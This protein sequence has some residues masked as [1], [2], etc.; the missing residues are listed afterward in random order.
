MDNSRRDELLEKIA[1][2]ETE[3]FLALPSAGGPSPAQQKPEIFKWT[4]KMTHAAHGEAFLESLLEDLQ[5]AKRQ[6]RNILQE[7]YE[8]AKNGDAHSDNPVADAIADVEAGFLAQAGEKYPEILKGGNAESFRYYLRQELEFLSPKTLQLYAQEL[9][10]AADQGKNP[11]I[12]RYNWMAKK[13]G[14]PG[15]TE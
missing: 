6:G 4:R 7:K 13:L 14:H 15:L 12:A 5:N 8:R 9:Q 11:A 2:M 10:E 1:D 3:M